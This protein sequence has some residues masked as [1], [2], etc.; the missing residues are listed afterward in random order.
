MPNS[1]TSQGPD[2]ST[3]IPAGDFHPFRS[4]KTPYGWGIR[5]TPTG[6][7]FGYIGEKSKCFGVCAALNG[8]WEVSKEL[9][10]DPPKTLPDDYYETRFG[11]CEV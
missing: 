2:L 9:L 1:E 5:H 3:Q 4:R 11:N 8:Q 6:S 10:G 7:I